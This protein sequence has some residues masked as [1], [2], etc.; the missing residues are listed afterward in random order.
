M[1]SSEDL[2]MAATIICWTSYGYWFTWRACEPPHIVI[3]SHGVHVNLLISHGVHVNH[4]T[5]LLVHMESIVWLESSHLQ[6]HVLIRLVHKDSTLY[7]KPCEVPWCSCVT[8]YVVP[9]LSAWSSSLG[10]QG[11]SGF[12]LKDSRESST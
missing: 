4:L 10:E 7:G 5:W 8:V 6:G 12:F 11:T 9:F 1:T 2:C 3:G